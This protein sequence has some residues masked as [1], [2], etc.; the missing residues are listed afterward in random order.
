VT[1]I[2]LILA[3]VAIGLV[4]TVVYAA[5]IV[6]SNVDDRMEEEE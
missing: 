3:V 2:I 5:L 1:T 4:R 6:G